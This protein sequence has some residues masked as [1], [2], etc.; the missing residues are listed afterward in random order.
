MA[1]LRIRSCTARYKDELEIPMAR[2]AGIINSD[3]LPVFREFVSR[4]EEEEPSKFIID[5]KNVSY[6]NSSGVGEL[7]RLSDTFESF[8]GTFIITSPSPEVFHLVELLGLDNLLPILPDPRYAV[9][10]FRKGTF[11]PATIAAVNRRLR[12]RMEPAA[13]RAAAPPLEPLGNYTLLMVP[14]KDFFVRFLQ[15]R[16]AGEKG[17][18]KIAKNTAQAKKKIRKSVPDMLIIDDGIENTNDL[19]FELKTDLRTNRTRVIKM[20]RYGTTPEKKFSGSDIYI[21]EDETITEPFD[22]NE[23]LALARREYVKYRRAKKIVSH[24]THFEIRSVPHAIENIYEML[25]RFLEMSPLRQDELSTFH[26]AVKEGIDNAYR[27]GNKKNE[28]KIIYVGFRMD[29][30]KITVVIEDEGNGFDFAYYLDAA[31]RLSAEQS[32]RLRHREGRTGGLGI[33]MMKKSS[34]GI[35]YTPPGNR[36]TLVKNIA[37]EAN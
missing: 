36:L 8:G 7:I 5:L 11:K 1:Q 4:L 23:L 25:Y 30:R 24:I 26:L 14:H 16:L 37:R 12:A 15:K 2:L 17:V 34:D 32:A 31:K 33:L 9:L 28:K 27:H 21:K 19:L 22:Y 20:L 13:A 6:V 3:T 10:L 29:A 18:L 35:S